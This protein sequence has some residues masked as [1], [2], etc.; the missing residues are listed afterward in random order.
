MLIITEGLEPP[1]VVEPGLEVK[2]SGQHF[3]GGYRQVPRTLIWSGTP[4]VVHNL[5]RKPKFLALVKD[6]TKA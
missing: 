3:Y 6:W 2:I 5:H 4:H 1:I